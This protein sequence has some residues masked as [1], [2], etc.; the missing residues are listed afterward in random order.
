MDPEGSR[1]TRNTDIIGNICILVFIT[2]KDDFPAND[3]E[4]IALAVIS[5]HAPFIGIYM[6]PH[7]YFSY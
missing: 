1:K 6:S 3:Q 5:G 7:A 2:V 4:A